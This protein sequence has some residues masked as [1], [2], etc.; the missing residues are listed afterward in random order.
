MA[1]K[2]VNDI[3]K[4]FE[5]LDIEELKVGLKIEILSLAYPIGQSYITQEDV[6][7]LT[8]LGFG[9]WERVKG[10]V[11]VGYDEDDENFNEIGKEGGESTHTLTAG[12][13]P[14]HL[15]S[16]TRSTVASTVIDLDNTY[17]NGATAV[18]KVTTATATTS[19]VGGNE[20]HNNLQPYKVVGYMWI[21]TA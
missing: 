12:E 3:N 5:D 20:S 19:S 1:G 11:L 7:P 10:K 13:L 15:H 17:N 14:E 8:I 6:N 2:L 16:Y 9:T 21:R 18:S 4:C